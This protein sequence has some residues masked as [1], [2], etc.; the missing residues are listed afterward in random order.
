[1]TDIVAELA[2]GRAV[3]GPL[4]LD[5]CHPR[6]WLI[7]PV[8][9]T[10][11]FLLPLDFSIVNVALPSI[12]A[13]LNA[14][15]G[16]LQLTMALYAVAYAVFLITGGRL[17]DLF[18]RKAMF[19]IGMVGFMAA[20]A[21]CGLA[22]SIHVLIAGRLL[23]GVAA[24]LMSPQVLATIR[25][26]FP[27]AERSLA[28]GYYGAMVGLALVLGQLCGG[29][30]IS[31]HPFGLSWQ[32]IFLVNLPIGALDL[33]A[34]I[35]AKRA[36]LERAGCRAGHSS[37]RR[38]LF[39]GIIGRSHAGAAPGAWRTGTGLCWRHRRAEPGDRGAAARR[40]AWRCDVRRDGDRGHRPGDCVPVA[41]PHR[42]A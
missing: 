33:A 26:I 21:A 18:G 34:A 17:G 19:L 27:P 39:S 29:L 28:L 37:L 32:S 23:Q 7:L 3:P 30:L 22:P 12:R 1:M 2:P 41:D 16:E 20:S 13:S 4:P 15:G 40:G 35:S 31:L 5:G 10:G 14:S 38:R 42:T 8:L 24:A 25:T 9:L 6:R 11:G 36:G